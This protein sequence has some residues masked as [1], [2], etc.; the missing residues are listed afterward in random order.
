MGQALCYVSLCVCVC[1]CVCLSVCVLLEISWP[2]CLPPAFHVGRLRPGEGTGQSHSLAE[3][4]WDGQLSTSLPNEGWLG[5]AAGRRHGWV[6]LLRQPSAETGVSLE[7]CVC[8]RR[9]NTDTRS[10]ARS[11]HHLN[12]CHW[13]G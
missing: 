2:S 4:G 10:P 7:V 6:L 11:A 3:P 8:E 13:V 5:W 12:W 1:V 9:E